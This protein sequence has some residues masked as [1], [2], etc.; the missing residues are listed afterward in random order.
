MLQNSHANRDSLAIQYAIGANMPLN[1][2]LREKSVVGAWI[3]RFKALSQMYE[4]NK[5]AIRLIN[6]SQYEPNVKYN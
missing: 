1:K 5:R 3:G 2:V 6:I 4:P